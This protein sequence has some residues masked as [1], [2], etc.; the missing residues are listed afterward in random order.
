[1]VATDNQIYGIVRPQSCSDLCLE[2][3]VFALIIVHW[4]NLLKVTSI[5]FESNEKIV[6]FFDFLLVNFSNDLNLNFQKGR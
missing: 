6:C 2:L 4:V 5:S 3:D 1:M